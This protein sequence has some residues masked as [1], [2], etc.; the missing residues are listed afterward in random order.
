MQVY[1]TFGHGHKRKLICE[2]KWLQ[3]YKCWFEF[4]EIG[5]TNVIVFKKCAE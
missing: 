2:E 4:I 3:K 5:Y 1:P